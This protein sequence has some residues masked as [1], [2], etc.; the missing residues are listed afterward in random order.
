MGWHPCFLKYVVLKHREIKG[1][2]PKKMPMKPPSP[3]ASSPTSS[4]MNEKQ[5][6]HMSTEN[7]VSTK[8][9]LQ[10]TFCVTCIELRLVDV[11]ACLHIEI[12]G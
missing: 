1:Y 3:L 6:Y 8:L 2:Q 12:K 11:A 5:S 10:E 9:S 4:D 7:I